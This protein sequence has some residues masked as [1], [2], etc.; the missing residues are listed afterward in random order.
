MYVAK[1]PSQAIG[2]TGG[3]RNLSYGR[4]SPLSVPAAGGRHSFR[5]SARGSE[6]RASKPADTHTG[7]SS[8]CH[9]IEPGFSQTLIFGH[10]PALWP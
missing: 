7:E 10:W 5:E 8:D 9:S 2:R 3:A 4:A 1:E 6:A